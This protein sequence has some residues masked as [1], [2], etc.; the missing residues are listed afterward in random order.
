[1]NNC[2]S[3][4]ADTLVSSEKCGMTSFKTCTFCVPTAIGPVV[5][6][7]IMAGKMRSREFR[8]GERGKEES[9]RNERGDE[10]GW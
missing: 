9:W 5:F 8:G 1:M 2:S 10:L 7:H 6:L 3:I 4:L